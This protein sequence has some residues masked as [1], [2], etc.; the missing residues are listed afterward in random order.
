M[1][2]SKNK[3]WLLLTAIA[4]VSI[5]AFAFFAACLP[6]VDPYAE[7]FA[8][9]AELEGERADLQEDILSL[10]TEVGITAL[11]E[12]YALVADLFGTADPV[13]AGI[14][15]QLATISTQLLSNPE[16]IALRAEIA[17]I[18]ELLEYYL[19]QVPAGFYVDNTRF[20]QL[21]HDNWFNSGIGQRG[22]EPTEQVFVRYNP[23]RVV[24]M[25]HAAL[26]HMILLG[27]ED[28][29]V[30]MAHASSPAHIE[31]AFPSSGPNMIPNISTF[32][33]HAPD[34][35]AIIRMR[36]DLIIMS[37]R[38]RARTAN[39][40]FARLSQIAPTLDLGT[41]SAP[42]AAQMA[43]ENAA[44][45]ELE[46]GEEI[47]IFE[48]YYVADAIDNM[49]IMGRIF[50]REDVADAY[51]EQLEATMAQIS[52]LQ[53]Q[54]NA[55]ALM[56]QLN[57]SNISLFGRNGRYS[58][59]FRELGLRGGQ[60]FRGTNNPQAAVNAEHQH[61]TTA[62]TTMMQ[63]INADIMIVVDRGNLTG[64]GTPSTADVLT[65]DLFANQFARQNDLI[66][67]VDG[68]KFYI[69]L[70]GLTAI[71]YRADVVLNALLA[72]QAVRAAG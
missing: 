50:Q 9:I 44:E 26:E 38:Q 68:A 28:R 10:R 64:D 8:R 43:L 33:P 37:G 57:G 63:H 16:Y 65:S 12:A 66:F 21:H 69:V 32:E 40:P 52:A 2:K 39:N 11:E 49:H 34:F 24:V 72:L 4:L 48:G 46:A 31:A 3:K 45:D 71:Q 61:G 35:A 60:I 14:R 1:S 67:R 47:D 19:A 15:A 36:P 56:V 30:G 41:R 29:V 7:I 70:G 20:F 25:C 58:M 6:Y 62:S 42:S 59:V 54:L 53:S 51:I 5:M 17:E 18:E 55:T 13:R 23:Q 22:V 27:V